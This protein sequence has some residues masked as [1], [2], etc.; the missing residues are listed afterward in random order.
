MYFLFFILFLIFEIGVRQ[1]MG[2]LNKSEDAWPKNNI[3][4]KVQ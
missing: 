3:K 2:K 1:E 4:D